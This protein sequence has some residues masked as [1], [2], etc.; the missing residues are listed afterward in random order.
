MR[1][2]ILGQREDVTLDDMLKDHYHYYLG[3]SH[4]PEEC[5]GCSKMISP[6]TWRANVDMINQEAKMVETQHICLTDCLVKASA[7]DARIP[8]FKGEIVVTSD[9]VASVDCNALSAES[10]TPINWITPQLF[11]TES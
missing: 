9:L 8:P 10:K 4:F 3:K 5:A 11:R 2:T 7:N 1:P 6:S